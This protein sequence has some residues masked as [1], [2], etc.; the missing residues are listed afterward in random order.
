MAQL[1]ATEAREDPAMAWLRQFEAQN[2]QGKLAMAVQALQLMGPKK[3]KRF[4]DSL[5]AANSG[6]REPAVPAARGRIMVPNPEQQKCSEI[7]HS[8]SPKDTEPRKV[9]FK[10]KTLL[11]ADVRGEK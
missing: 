4:I 10:F 7:L 2:Y 1:I 9:G 11:S 6:T 5:E 3:A 8:V